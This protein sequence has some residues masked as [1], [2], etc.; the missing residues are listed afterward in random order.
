MGIYLLSLLLLAGPRKVIV[1]G[2]IALLVLNLVTF[3]KT[4][5]PRDIINKSARSASV[6]INHLKT[7]NPDSEHR[8]K[9]S[10]PLNWFQNDS[11]QVFLLHSNHSYFWVN[12]MPY[13]SF[14]NDFL[15]KRFTCMN[16]ILRENGFH[17]INQEVL[18][19]HGVSNKIQFYTKWNRLFSIL[20][21][22]SLVFNF[23]SIDK[24]REQVGIAESE[25]DPVECRI[26]YRKH[27]E[28][29]LAGSGV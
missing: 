20:N 29:I 25:L 16:L 23:D 19:V 28:A 6:Q 18:E 24:F 3:A 21:W 11:Y 8:D 22:D 10:I 2:L 7:M 4:M 13:F 15:F 26:E 14:S 17:E 1:L 9:I 27:G 5:S 12:E